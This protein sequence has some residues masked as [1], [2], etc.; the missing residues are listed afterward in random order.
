[1]KRPIITTID[2]IV[3]MLKDYTNGQIP[4][5]GQAVALKF[6][7]AEK[8]KLGIE[9]YSNN[10]TEPGDGPIEVKFEIRRIFGAS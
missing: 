3:E 5:D 7:P 10:W 1:M 9:V 4:L 8:G 2:S 6:K